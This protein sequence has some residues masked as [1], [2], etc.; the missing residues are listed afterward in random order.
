MKTRFISRV[1]VFVTSVSLGLSFFYVSSPVCAA[2]FASKEEVIYARL[3]ASGSA[4]R[5]D[6]VNIFPN[7]QTGTITD[8]GDYSS[9]TNMKGTEEVTLVKDQVTI[10]KGEKALYYEGEL[11]SQELPWSVN[12]EYR[13]DSKV[14]SP[15]EI[16][17]K[18]GALSMAIHIAKGSEKYTSF[19]EDYALQMSL[20]LDT[21][22]AS[23][24]VSEDATIANVGKYKQLSY[25][26]LPGEGTDVTIKADVNDFEMEGIS[27]NAVPLSMSLEAFELGDFSN[28]E[29]LPDATGKLSDATGTLLNGANSVR[30]G[31]SGLHDAT[32][33]LING[34]NTLA[35]GSAQF[36]ESLGTYQANMHALRDSSKGLKDALSQMTPET[37]SAMGLHEMQIQSLYPLLSASGTVCD[38]IA[39]LSQGTDGLCDGYESL[40]AG[41]RSLPENAKKLNEGTGA[42]LNGTNQLADGTGQLR[43][44][45]DSLNREVTSFVRDNDISG[46]IEKLQSLKDALSGDIETVSFVSDKNVEVESVL[47][48]LQTDAVEIIVP[49]Q[50]APKDEKPLGAFEKFV[51]LFKS[52]FEKN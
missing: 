26:V 23:H 28:V 30:D 20:R 38:N 19:Y 10:Q 41:I 15:K 32:G 39:L 12:V 45:A 4:N 40:D 44:G 51:N 7:N 37:L 25:I 48:V 52:P 31:V 11:K 14:Y 3:D 24:I 35:Q 29:K 8:F 27:I 21:E 46:K 17:G 13:L 1:F 42:L 50:E 6:V 33:A 47:F 16:A 5:V 36:K 2:S 18:S 22:K 9:A 43:S 34:A 49:E